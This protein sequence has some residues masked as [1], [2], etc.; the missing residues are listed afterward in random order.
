MCHHFL[1]PGP[2]HRAFY[3]L[4]T[5]SKK[6]K[7]PLSS[8]F[9]CSPIWLKSISELFDLK[10]QIILV[11]SNESNRAW[12]INCFT[13]CT[14][15]SSPYLSYC[16]EVWGSNYKSNVQSLFILQERATPGAGHGG[17]SH[18]LFLQSHLLTF[19]DLGEFQIA[20]IRHKPKTN[21][22]NCLQISNNWGEA[23]ISEVTLTS[24][25]LSC[26]QWEGTSVVLK[27]WVYRTVGIR[28]WRNEQQVFKKRDKEMIFSSYMNKNHRIIKV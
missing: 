22:T 19:A 12:I 6:K 25:L 15:Q 27:V 26:V 21:P 20:Q 8:N 24:E 18:P 28:D 10:A 5:D 1:P 9:I 4:I 3:W 17:R 23:V 14:V 7:S 13:F 2:W 16:I 11:L